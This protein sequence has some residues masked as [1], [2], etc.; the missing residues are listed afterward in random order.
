MIRIHDY[1]MFGIS[2]SMLNPASFESELEHLAAVKQCCDFS[3]YENFETFLPDD[4]VI[5][6]TE[7]QMMKDA[8]KTLNYNTPLIFQLDGEYNCGSD[9]PEFRKKALDLAKRHLNYA[10]E[11]GSSLFVVT[12]CP[13]KGAELR[14]TLF[15]RYDE[16]FCKVA[17]YAKQ[18]GITVLIEPIEREGFKKLLLGP[19]SECAETVERARAMG[20]WN[21]GLM[22]DVM[23][24]PLMGEDF[25]R[26]LAESMKA[27]LHLVHMGD[28]VTEA[29]H[30][31]FGHT[32]PPLG[33][34][35]GRFDQEDYTDQFLK[36]LESGYISSTPVKD[37]RP[38]ISLEVRPYPGVSGPTS[39]RVFYEKI[40]S[41]FSEALELY[42]PAKD[43][44]GK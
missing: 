31:F 3:E 33:I 38:N 23:H 37:K 40:S 10:A 27:G 16:Y 5:R 28:C 2:P 29:G 39:A 36:F 4:E 42:R 32:H 35:G 9:N 8:G 17:E 18:F 13:D 30:K 15:K 22:L 12:G 19:T 14:P 25:G 24:L 6:K 44:R 43:G 26:A 20:H 7:I 1:F 41:A 34:Q 21:V 11:A